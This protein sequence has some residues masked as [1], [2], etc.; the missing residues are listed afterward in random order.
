M[1]VQRT[2][3]MVKAGVREK[4]A[5]AGVSSSDVNFGDIFGGLTNPFD[6]LRSKHVILRRTP[7]LNCEC[8]CNMVRY[9][10]Y[11]QAVH[12]TILS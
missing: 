11:L 2:S 1:Q 10:L 6:G 9:F 7:W 4:L 3:E 8:M 5:E 12:T